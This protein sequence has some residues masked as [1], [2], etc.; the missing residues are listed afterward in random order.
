MSKV[1][2]VK[3]K[4]PDHPD[5]EVVINKSDLTPEDVVVGEDKPKKTTKRK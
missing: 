3:V 1:E 5:G 4:R 2:T